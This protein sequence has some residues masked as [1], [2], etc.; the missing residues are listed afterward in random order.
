MKDIIKRVITKQVIALFAIV[1]IG[2]AGL[3][4]SVTA[5]KT[6]AADCDSNAIIYCGTSQGSLPSKYN[7]LD[8]KGKAAFA[9]AGVVPSQLGKTVIGSVTRDNK[10]IVNGKVVATNVYTYGRS[11]MAGSTQI[12]GGAYMR[13]PSVSFRSSSISAYVHMEGKEFKW[14]V[15]SSCGN[16]V[17]G[18][19]TFK[20][21]PK[22]SLVKTVNKSHVKVGKVF[23]YTITTKNIGN[24]AL[25]NVVMKDLLPDGIVMANG[26]KG[27]PRIF[28]YG[29]LQPGQTK[30]QVLRVKAVKGVKYDVRLRNLACVTTNYNPTLP[31]CD[32]AFVTVKKPKSPTPPPT[33]EEPTPEEPTPEV[34]T[35]EVPQKPEVITELPN[36]GAGSVLGIFSVTS[37]LGTVVHRIL[38]RS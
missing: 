4:T 35:P 10:V 3:V 28:K 6:V 19:P 5:N 17:K 26:L 20:N 18:T 29:T 14:A 25:H 11:Y 38:R 23:N 34:P 1:F 8:G 16:P 27:N 22:I 24:V 30:K 32:D 12:S 36:T 9:H 31:I 7:S 13:H 37:I 21:R 2:I 33:P 15:I